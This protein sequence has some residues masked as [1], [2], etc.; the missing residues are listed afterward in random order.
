MK[1]TSPDEVAM[2]MDGAQRVVIVPGYGMAVAQAQHAV[3]D[4]A[5][6][7]ESKGIAVEFAIHPEGIYLYVC[8][9]VSDS[10]TVLP[11]NADGSLM[12]SIS[13][14]TPWVLFCTTPLSA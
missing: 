2:L 8:N 12:P 11:V 14:S 4:L 7:L 13:S 9:V 6:L 10:L 3:R 5:N 1:A